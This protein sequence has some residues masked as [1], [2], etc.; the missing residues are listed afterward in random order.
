MTLRSPFV[1]LRALLLAVSLLG[2]APALALAA[3]AP[4]WPQSRTDIKA[5]PEV[6]FGVLPNGMRYAIQHNAT[7]TGQASLR[8]R[9][10]AGSLMETDA[11][12]GVA[13]FLE[14]MAFKGSK[15]VPKGD[16]VEI[17]ERHGLAFGA[18]TNAQTSWTQ[19]VY[20]L[21]LPRTDEDTVDT[22][23]MLL[24]DVA[25]E[26]LLAPAA[27]DS[28]RGVVLA[29]ERTRDT[30]GLRVFK[31]GLSFF[32]KDQLA[33]RR[34]PI[35]KVQVIEHAD[36][37]LLGG[38]YRQYYQPER[39]TIVAVGDF[40]VDAMEAKIKARFSD[41]KPAAP[42]GPEPDLGQ[43]IQRG[44]QAKL[45][46][47]PGAP[48]SIQIYWVK[49]HDS[50][51]DSV[52]RRRRKLIEQLGLAVLNRRLGQIAR[53]QTPPFIAAQSS[54]DDAFRSAEATALAV[55]A[56]PDHWRQALTAAEQ[57]ERR[58]VQYGVRQDE[59]DR[60]IKEVLVQLQQAAAGAGTRRTP[61]IAGEITDTLDD[62]LVYTDPVQDLAMF[63]QAV[64]GLTAETV[65]QTLKEVFSGDGPLLYVATPQPIEG[66][67]QALV[68]AWKASEA[69]PVQAPKG[70][71]VK[72]WPY[73]DFGKPGQVV[74]RTTVDDL[75]TTFVRFANG[76]R[77]TVKPTKFRKDQVLVRVRFGHGQLEMPK[78][79][80]T[81]AWAAR[82]ALVEGGLKD[83]SAEDIERVLASNIYDA[84]FG[85]TDD[86]FVLGG[87]TRPQDLLVQMQLL[88]AYDIDP[89]FRPQAFQ[90]MKTYMATLYGQLDA[91]PEG[92]M[93]RELSQLLHGGDL[94]YAFPSPAD[95]ADAT[96]QQ[97]QAL[98]K[99][100]LAEGPLEVL[101]VG[102]TTVDQA[103]QVTAATFGAL[104]PRKPDPLPPPAAQ[105]MPL[106]GPQPTPVELTH[107][108][109]ADQAIAYAA[110]PTDG[111]FADPQRAR[112]LRVVAQVMENRMIDDLRKAAG[113]TYSPQ[114]GATASLVFPNY[115]Y[116]SAVVEIPPAKLDDF[117]RD[118]A[119]ISTDLRTNL[120]SA[121]ELQRAR[122][123]LVEQLL[124]A[125]QT[126]DYWIEQLSGAQDD[127]RRIHALRTVLNSL[128]K[129]DP[130]QI[131]DAARMYLRDDRLWRLEIRPAAQA[132]PAAPAA[133]K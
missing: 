39:A 77:L 11:E 5:A 24:R 45:T 53:S 76:V 51:M 110:W 58:I 127:P 101:I 27:I 16:M 32:L 54:K 82:G 65:S 125:R 69:T 46:V 86:A 124:K 55:S 20:Q 117:T 30:P 17:L 3:P 95:V 70:E 61:R 59:L 48:L 57:E 93:S 68:D 49:P 84:E 116:V 120:V 133:A 73:T 12:Q 83:L 43:P 31:S 96:P 4:S 62:D 9:I 121:D 37:A 94:R 25:G 80:V 7:P 98:L 44:F 103:I 66:G 13:H 123:P 2:T 129:V 90:R 23:L 64:K 6:R 79:R 33:S 107:K 29:E 50:T 115:G 104:P 132:G 99:P 92:V 21:D 75:G 36:R 109:R 97:F 130:E 105:G 85:T 56:Q 38:F 87:S 122:K 89:G 26:L 131:R 28:E 18:D 106:P 128:A 52:A 14:H 119:K 113:D 78:D 60:E 88:A 35:G 91:T 22:S 42:E 8:L 108:G 118:L 40:D 71:T 19:T 41:W 34:L 72:S 111:F 10:D 63:Q 1:A 47:E 114:A 112:T 15:H 67:E 74:R 81:T 100:R 126:N 102:D